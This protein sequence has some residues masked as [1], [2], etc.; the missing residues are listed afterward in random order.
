MMWSDGQTRSR[1]HG[2]SGQG[3]LFEQVRTGRLSA[4]PRAAYA[5]APPTAK[6]D[7]TRMV[8]IIWLRRSSPAHGE[9]SSSALGT[10]CMRAC[11]AGEASSVL[12][13][14]RARGSLAAIAV[15]GMGRARSMRRVS[16][17]A[18]CMLAAR[19]CVCRS[20]NRHY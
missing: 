2:I 12:M 8:A 20:R 13:S 1:E 11:A 9:S 18:R 15:V 16:M 10:K 3:T 7:G 14:G 19:A 6:V 4:G 5:P 17:Q